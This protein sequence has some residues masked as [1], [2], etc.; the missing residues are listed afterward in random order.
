M[1][2]EPDPHEP[3]RPARYSALI[4]RS[5]GGSTREYRDGEKSRREITFENGSRQIHIGRLDLG[6]GYRIEEAEKIYIPIKLA[7]AMIAAIRS[8]QNEGRRWTKLRE[9]DVEGE[10]CTVFMTETP[11]LEGLERTPT[12]VKE[13]IHISQITSWYRRMTTFDKF[14]NVGVIIDWLEVSFEP[15]PP[16]LFEPPADYAEFSLAKGRVVNRRK[17]KPRA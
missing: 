9:E 4:Q 17:A 10:P 16:E 11:I 8:R 14:S 15:I 13:L 12:L 5:N 1:S 7:P 3:E 2:D 6:L